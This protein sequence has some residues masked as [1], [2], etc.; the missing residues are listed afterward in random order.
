MP[1]MDFSLLNLP[2]KT[3]VKISKLKPSVIH[4]KCRDT[5]LRR[6]QHSLSCFLF[7]QTTE[8]SLITSHYLEKSGTGALIKIFHYQ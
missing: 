7:V 3:I 2:I 1:L 8:E 6:I 5:F 4:Q